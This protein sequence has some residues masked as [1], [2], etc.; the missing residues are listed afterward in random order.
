MANFAGDGF[1]RWHTQLSINAPAQ[2]K[3]PQ[4]SAH[5]DIASIHSCDHDSQVHPRVPYQVPKPLVLEFL[6]S[7]ILIV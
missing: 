7:I 6:N 1:R 3:K 5:S 2:S 4:N